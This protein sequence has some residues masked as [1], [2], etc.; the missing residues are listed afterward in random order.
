MSA[1]YQKILVAVDDG[2]ASGWAQQEAVFLAHDLRADLAILHVIDTG[3]SF[4][5]DW[6][7]AEDEVLAAKRREGDDLL[8]HAAA[9]AHADPAMSVESL[10]R[11][12]AP[13]AQIVQTAR[14]WGAD[15]VVMGSHGRGRL[16]DLVQGSTTRTVI[17]DAP[18]PVL[19]VSHEP[20]GI[21]QR[22]LAAVAAC[23]P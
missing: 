2:P 1:S 9:R 22:T 14:A 16:G 4:P 5:V 11:E 15:L 10:L 18:C 12:G 23:G 8:R 3:F 13:A 6:N 19:I 7:Y 20:R 21:P 17:R